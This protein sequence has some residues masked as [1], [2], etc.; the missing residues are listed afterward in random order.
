MEQ[1]TTHTMAYRIC[2]ILINAGRTT[3]LA[4]KLDVYFGA[5]RVTNEEYLELIDMLLM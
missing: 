4:D 5:G 3:G 1:A 2:M